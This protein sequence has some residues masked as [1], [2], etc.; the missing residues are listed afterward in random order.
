[1]TS[2][3]DETVRCKLAVT[4]TYLDIWLMRRVVN[5]IRVGYS[6]T[7]YAMWVL[8]RDIRRKSLPELVEILI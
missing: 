1:M 7:S 4:A 3:D 6:S 8:F 5:Y 2:D